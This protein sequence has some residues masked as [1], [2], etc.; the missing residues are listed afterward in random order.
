M[1]QNI[2]VLIVDDEDRSR[3]VLIDYLN[4]YC[5]NVNIVGEAT[6][7]LD[8]VKKINECHPKL[9][10]LDIEMPGGNGFELF[11]FF[12][13]PDFLVVFVTAY[14]DFAIK[15]FEVS[16]LDYLTKPIK[17]KQLIK[18]VQRAKEQINTKLYAEQLKNMKSEMTEGNY[19][20][21]IA[22]PH[23]NGIQFF[24]ID[25]IQ[26]IE[27]DG[28]YSNIKY[29]DEIIL[30]A[31]KLSEIEKAINHPKLFKTHRSFI[32]NLDK[33]SKVTKTEGDIIIMN[34]GKQ[35]PLS[36]YRKDEF[37]EKIQNLG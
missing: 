10:F 5:P 3:N 32:I 33:I 34:C 4:E 6:N 23:S 26:F 1:E 31:K 29:N 16:A 22:L 19:T 8:A 20:Q 36:R 18:T 25:G 9:V 12:D 28:S 35:I 13:T 27:A 7:V 30:A 21:R 17:I 2:D 15:A 14:Q 24:D 37:Y 11:D